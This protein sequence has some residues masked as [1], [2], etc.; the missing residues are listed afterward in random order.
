M[1]SFAGYTSRK[2]SQV[3]VADGKYFET[4]M[5]CLPF[6]VS[7]VSR[8]VYGQG[9]NDHSVVNFLF[10]KITENFDGVLIIR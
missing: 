9:E 4:N 1:K 7:E 2:Y 8:S 6:I 10:I 3:S 5:R